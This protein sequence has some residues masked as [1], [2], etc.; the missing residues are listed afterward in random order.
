MSILLTRSSSEFNES[1]TSNLLVTAAP[2]TIA[3]WFYLVVD[4][5]TIDAALGG[6]MASDESANVFRLRNAAINQKIEHRTRSTSPSAGPD[7]GATTSTISQDTWHQVTFRAV[8]STSRFAHLD[9][10]TGDPE[11]TVDITPS[12]LNQFSLGNLR[13]SLSTSYW[14]GRIAEVGIW[15]IA[16]SSGDVTNLSTNKWAPELVQPANLQH[17]FRFTTFDDDS[18]RGLGSL[19]WESN[20]GA[21]ADHPPGIV[22]ASGDAAIGYPMAQ[23]G[24][25]LPGPAIGVGY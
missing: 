6:L 12:G 14:D 15:N 2:L 9:G 3:M 18:D 8:S 17:Y 22:Y 4:P 25:V 21:T 10:S 5:S 11:A 20:N 1:D 24:D 19:T 13:G 23:S 7:D 16:L